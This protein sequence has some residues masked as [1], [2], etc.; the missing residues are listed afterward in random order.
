MVGCDAKS[1]CLT[2]TQ[3]SSLLVRPGYQH[4]VGRPAPELTLVGTWKLSDAVMTGA[5][6][7]KLPESMHETDC[8]EEEYRD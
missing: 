5:V 6:L 4:Q 1:V 3:L 8:K 2:Q 7:A